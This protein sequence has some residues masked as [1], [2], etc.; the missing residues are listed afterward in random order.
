MTLKVGEGGGGGILK[1]RIYDI[2]F[3][4]ESLSNAPY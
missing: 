2:N 3:S 1:A 4:R